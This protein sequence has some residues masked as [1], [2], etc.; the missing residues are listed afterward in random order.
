MKNATPILAV[1]LLLL[2]CPPSVEKSPPGLAPTPDPAV[3]ATPATPEAPP[4]GMAGGPHPGLL[5]PSKATE[6]APESFSVSFVT[7]KGSFVVEV[8]RAW[9]PNGA[10]RFYNLV[11]IGYFTDVHFFRVLK[12]FMAQF[13]I[14]GNPQ[15]NEQ[16]QKARIPDDA[17]AQSNSRGMITFATAGKNTRT[18]QLF[19]NYGNN[20]NLDP[21]GFTP[22]G[23]VTSGMK[24]VDALYA[25]YGEGAPR[26]RGPDQGR[27]QGEGNVY[28]NA[29]FP[30]LDQVKTV[31]LVQ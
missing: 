13:G 24:V 21:M 3:P 12:G 29:N 17:A 26:G 10:D 31:T 11:K 14:N 5:D 25:G 27:T 7:T 6:T 22:F 1:C 4:R 18:T 15:V 28:L 16:W 23:R 30:K 9:A 8:T 2:G 19:I 20:A